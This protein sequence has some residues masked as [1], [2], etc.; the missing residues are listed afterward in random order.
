MHASAS[1]AL[2]ALPGVR[3]L[4]LRG[5]GAPACRALAGCGALPQLERLRMQGYESGKRGEGIDFFWGLSKAGALLSSLT[6]LELHTERDRIDGEDTQV[7]AT[8]CPALRELSLSGVE[9]GSSGNWAAARLPHLTRLRVTGDL[10]CGAPL[11]D[12]APAGCRLRRG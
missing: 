9:T 3:D 10:D 2:A 8:L 12:W 11:A 4:E 7:I 6:Y 5:G 1:E